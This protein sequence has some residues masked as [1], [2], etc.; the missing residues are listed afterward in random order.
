MSRPVFYV[1]KELYEEGFGEVTEEKTAEQKEVQM[2]KEQ[3]EEKK[4][5]HHPKQMPEKGLKKSALHW[6]DAVAEEVIAR[7]ERNPQL[8]A[9]VE[10]NGFFVY[11]EKTPSGNIHIGSGRGWIIHDIIA[12][13]LREKGVNARF[14][15]SS[16]DLLPELAWRLVRPE[17][18][19]P[20]CRDCA[21]KLHFGKREQVR[22]DLVWGLWGP[23]F[24][25]LERWYWA[26]R[27]EGAYRLPKNWDKETYPLWPREFGGQS[28][29]TGS[30]A[31]WCADPRGYEKVHRTKAQ[32]KV[33]SDAFS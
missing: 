2:K 18:A 4:Q 22:H 25:A 1:K 13:A 24:E 21:R 26:V 33:L 9:V 11:D 30:G 15:L 28:W 7:V 14:V 5:K 23:R 8:K 3:V 10:K 17:N 20:L 19:V 29:Q 16:D 32:K 31:I 27:G 12:K 6:A